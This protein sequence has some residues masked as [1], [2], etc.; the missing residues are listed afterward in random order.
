M[1]NVKGFYPRGE[2]WVTVYSADR[3][4]DEQKLMMLDGCHTVT[5]EWVDL[6]L[7]WTGTVKDPIRVRDIEVAT[8]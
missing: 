2:E 5:I 8:P 3:A 6:K 1:F 7:I 4:V